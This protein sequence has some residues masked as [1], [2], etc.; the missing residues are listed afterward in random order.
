MTRANYLASP[1][2]VIAYSLAG[3]VCIDFEKEPVGIDSGGKPVFLREIWPSRE[4]IQ[5]A[6]RTFVL[7]GMFR[8]VYGKI[9]EGNLK[10]NSLEVISFFSS[11]SVLPNLSLGARLTSLP[12]G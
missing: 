12:L 1:L 8:E 4:E 6:E 5:I 2:L 7:P 11:D 3:T 10:W 9:T